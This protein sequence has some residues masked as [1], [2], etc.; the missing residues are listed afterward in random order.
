M[1]ATEKVRTII[2]MGKARTLIRTDKE[3]ADRA[4]YIPATLCTKMK[5]PQRM[6]VGDIAVLDA[7]LHFTETEIAELVRACR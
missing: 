3:L 6:T 5:R 4:G 2:D 7:I 1:G